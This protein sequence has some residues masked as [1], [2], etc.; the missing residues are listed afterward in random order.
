MGGGVNHMYTICM[1]KLVEV[2]LS[3]NL[4]DTVSD[5]VNSQKSPEEFIL[6]KQIMLSIGFAFQEL[7][8]FEILKMYYC[9]R[10][11]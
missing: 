7:L 4:Q 1:T 5:P 8:D 9:L 11:C 3:L 2:Q 10:F 6:Q